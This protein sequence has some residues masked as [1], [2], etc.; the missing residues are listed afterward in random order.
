MSVERLNRV[1]LRGSAG[2]GTARICRADLHFG[3]EPVSV[4]KGIGNGFL[5]WMVLRCVY[6]QNHEISRASC[7]RAVDAEG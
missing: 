1:R 6:C 7:G 5:Q 4:V 2:S 3:E